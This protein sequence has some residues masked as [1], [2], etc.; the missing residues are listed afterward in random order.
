[1]VRSCVA[2]ATAMQGAQDMT[3]SGSLSRGTTNEFDQSLFSSTLVAGG[4]AAGFVVPGLAEALRPLLLP[5]LFV[6]MV[7][8]LFPSRKAIG[9]TLLS[10]D[11]RAVAAVTWL[12]L[13]LPAAVL[14]ASL[15]L[16]VPQNITVFVLFSA[17]CSTVFASPTIA[18]LL[19]LDQVL[20]TRIMIL[21][22]I[23]A[24]FSIAVFMGP[25]VDGVDMLSVGVFAERVVLFLVV[26]MALVVLLSIVERPKLA[27][28]YRSADKASQLTGMIALSVF[29]IALM[30]DVP[31]KFAEDLPLMGAMFLGVVGVNAGMAVVSIYVFNQAKFETAFLLG[32]LSMM[33]NVGLGL[34]MVSSFFG[35]ELACYIALCQVPLMIVPL[36]V[37]LR[38][39]RAIPVRASGKVA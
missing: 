2:G 34:A 8:S 37:R 11:K 1:M 3:T 24:P 32:L 25:I 31:Q 39:T 27:P 17:C 26:P 35:A 18:R 33:R 4:M 30:D 12:Q 28:V 14:A 9:S 20:A 38:S 15:I 13:W 7:A 16:Q 5:S 21:S 10:W 29:A 19:D 22:T 36:F 6:I 23:A